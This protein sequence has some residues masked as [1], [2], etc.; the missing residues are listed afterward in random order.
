MGASS[1]L[2]AVVGFFTPAGASALAG[3]SSRIAGA[4]AA[5]VVGLALLGWGIY[6]T[7]HDRA[8]AFASG[9][10]PTAVFSTG[11]IIMIAYVGGLD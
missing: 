11:I 5:A 4:V 10:W 1:G 7:M 3:S 6:M 8:V 9:L 2:G